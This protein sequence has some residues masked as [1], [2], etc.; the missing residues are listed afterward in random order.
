MSINLSIIKCSDEQEIICDAYW[1]LNDAGEFVYSLSDIR[2]TLNLRVRN[3]ASYVRRY[4]GAESEA[5]KCTNCN[6]PYVYKSRRDYSRHKDVVSWE[7]G[8]CSSTG[9][10]VFLTS[11]TLSNMMSEN[12]EFDA[13]NLI[14]LNIL[15]KVFL[16]TALVGLADESFSYTCRAGSLDDAALT[17]DDLLD[18]K[19]IKRLLD[20]GLLKFPDHLKSLS[21]E[22]V[23]SDEFLFHL[24]TESLEFSILPNVLSNFLKEMDSSEV[25]KQIV[26]DGGFLMLCREVS[27]FECISFL[28]DQLDRHGFPF[29][30]GEKTK[31]VILK[32]LQDYSVGET[33]VFIWRSVRDSASFYLRENISK[34]Y[35]A[36]AVIGNIERQYEKTK[37]NDWV[38]DGFKRNNYLPQSV[39]SRVIFNQILG[40]DDGGFK[41]KLSDL[42][43]Y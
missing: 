16:M 8:K 43:P 25:K 42:M 5:I 7:C 12:K 37:A 20:L 35:A 39:I 2:S 31:V 27:L 19:I 34:I 13:N 23:E 3:L 18:G 33:C 28:L 15:D 24:R 22:L 10:E 29:S 32:C 36:N 30:P 1:K 41:Q 6:F 11:Q 21:R 17:P 14:N 26:E 40:T 38:M 9:D 4:S